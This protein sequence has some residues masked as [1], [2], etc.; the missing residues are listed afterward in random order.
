MVGFLTALLTIFIAWQRRRPIWFFEPS[1]G[2]FF[3]LFFA[4]LE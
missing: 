4:N 3:A 1:R 2:G